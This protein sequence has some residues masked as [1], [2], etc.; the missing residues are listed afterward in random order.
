[1]DDIVNIDDRKFLPVSN[2]AATNVTAWNETIHNG[3]PIDWGYWKRL[4]NIT[5]AQAAKLAHFIDPISW[6]DAKYAAGKPYDERFNGEQIDKE[7]PEKI[8]RLKQRLDNHSPQ[9][10]LAT[11]VCFLG[12]DNSPFCMRQAVEEPAELLN[13]RQNALAEIAAQRPNLY[14]EYKITLDEIITTVKSEP[15]P[16]NSRLEDRA[17]RFVW[18]NILHD[19]KATVCKSPSSD[20]R[21]NEIDQLNQ[22]ITAIQR[23]LGCADNRQ[24]SDNSKPGHQHEIFGDAGT[25]S[26]G[27]KI[28]NSINQADNSNDGK[29]KERQDIRG[30]LMDG[31]EQINPF[32]KAK[33]EYSLLE[34][35]YLVAGENPKTYAEF[36][37]EKN[38]IIVSFIGQVL[39]YFSKIPEYKELKAK[40]LSSGNKLDQE[41]IICGLQIPTRVANILATELN[42]LPISVKPHDMAIN[43]PAV[44][45]K[46][47]VAE[48]TPS[49]TQTEEPKPS[50]VHDP[51]ERIAALFDPVS[52]ET[53]AQMFPVDKHDNLA[54]WQ[55]WTERASRNRLNAARVERAKFNPYKA[56]MWLVDKGAKGWD[57]ARIKRV[58]IKNLPARS[59][60][61]SD[62][63][64]LKG[65][66]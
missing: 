3:K 55:R 32:W 59:L 65:D 10:N 21:V 37:E 8:R 15:L 35:A 64:L 22:A 50:L 48:E 25:V 44:C 41:R 33:T 19:R 42:V 20:A 39:D 61:E 31:K 34:L 26:Q 17:K 36:R 29:P 43:T 49:L 28:T 5:P 18:L 9:W 13:A 11:L 4:D 2:D 47:P 60:H 52:V 45:F 62:A 66:L 24:Q 7:L 56:G 6:P 53:L 38:Q 40:I 16:E 14:A 58:L 63:D 57:V 12:E 23:Q 27:D 54:Q 51:A 1:M 30:C 46:K